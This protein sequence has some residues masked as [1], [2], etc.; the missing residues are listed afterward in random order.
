MKGRTLNKYHNQLD[1]FQTTQPQLSNPHIYHQH[2]I[3]AMKVNSQI[4]DE[5]TSNI[6]PSPITHPSRFPQF[7][8][9]GI[10]VGDTSFTLAP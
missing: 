7:T 4:L 1:A 5:E 6:L 9:I 8:H 10:D 3:I 2:Q